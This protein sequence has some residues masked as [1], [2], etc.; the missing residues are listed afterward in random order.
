YAVPLRAVSDSLRAEAQADD[1]I[2][3]D[4][5]IA[6]QYYWQQPPRPAAPLYL[7]D[8]DSRARARA[9]I[10][11]ARAPRVFLLTYGRDRSRTND[12]TDEFMEWLA[13][14]YAQRDERAHVPIDPLY[15][16]VKDWLFQR[17]TYQAKLTVRMFERKP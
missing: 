7:T 9:A 14:R 3:S 11:T 5:D 4:L 6:L 15:R 13:P 1:L 8:D 12:H 16:A 2:I 17:E 10:E